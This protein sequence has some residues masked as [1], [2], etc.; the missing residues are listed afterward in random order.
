[1]C[2]FVCIFYI[3]NTAKGNTSLMLD[4]LLLLQP[5]PIDSYLLLFTL[6]NSYLQCIRRMTAKLLL[7]LGL[8]GVLVALAEGK[9]FPTIDIC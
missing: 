5:T 2:I 6:I 1:M 9:R 7:V 4:K 3:N 8:S